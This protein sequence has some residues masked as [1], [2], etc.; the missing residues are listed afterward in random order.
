MEVA[1]NSH[2]RTPKTSGR[3]TIPHGC[4]SDEA[5]RTA[6]LLE[7]ILH[8]IERQEFTEGDCPDSVK[9]GTPASIP[10]QCRSS[11][12]SNRPLARAHAPAAGHFWRGS[13]AFPSPLPEIEIPAPSCHLLGTVEM[14]V[15]MEKLCHATPNHEYLPVLAARNAGTRAEPRIVPRGAGVISMLN[16]EGKAATRLRTNQ[17]DGSGRF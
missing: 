8:M 10:S 17:R 1:G 12:Q 16:A 5:H 6:G 3:N 15:E 7:Q 4:G 2:R 9:R 14:V 11:G 13:F